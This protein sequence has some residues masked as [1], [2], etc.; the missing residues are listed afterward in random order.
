MARVLALL[1]DLQPNQADATKVDLTVC[2]H[3]SPT[4]SETFTPQRI[5]VIALLTPSDN[6]NTL[7]NT[8]ENAIITAVQAMDT[9]PAPVLTQANIIITKFS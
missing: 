8:V 9:I 7:N 1:C 2:T 5:D 6:I 4:G 3:V